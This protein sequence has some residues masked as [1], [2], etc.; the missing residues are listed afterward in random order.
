MASASAGGASIDPVLETEMLWTAPGHVTAR[1]R[2][3]FIQVRAAELTLDAMASIEM[4]ARLMRAQMPRAEPYGAMIVILPRAPQVV[5]EAAKKQ[6]ALLANLGED[7]RLHLAIV[8]EGDSVGVMAQRAV[9]RAVLRTTRRQVCGTIPDAARALVGVI[10]GLG[11]Q[12]GLVAFV[13][14]LRAKL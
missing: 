3:V 4:G 8:L 7:E 10:G 11:T 9:A 1:W 5:G 2:N 12:S 6:R 14:S 13:E